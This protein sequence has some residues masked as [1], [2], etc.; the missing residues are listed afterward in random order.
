MPSTRFVKFPMTQRVWDQVVVDSE[1]PYYG[2]TNESTESFTVEFVS[3]RDAEDCIAR[4]EGN[5]PYEFLEPEL[6][7]VG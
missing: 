7:V 2:V 4:L 3:V 6:E 1:E 5:V